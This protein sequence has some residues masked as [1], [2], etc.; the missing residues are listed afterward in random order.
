MLFLPPGKFITSDEIAQF[1]FSL[2]D[3]IKDERCDFFSYHSNNGD[4][5]PPKTNPWK[6]EFLKIE[7]TS[8]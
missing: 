4:A 7:M 6:I 3:E 2:E 5:L 1:F 8:R